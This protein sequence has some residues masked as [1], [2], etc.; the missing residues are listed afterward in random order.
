MKQLKKLIPVDFEL[1]AKPKIETG[2]Y[3]N[4]TKEEK[5]KVLLRK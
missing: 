4:D 5:F 3:E 2:L 1:N